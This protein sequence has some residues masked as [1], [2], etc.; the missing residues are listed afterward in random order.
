MSMSLGDIAVKYGCELHGDPSQQVT[1][2][3][4][5]SGAGGEAIAFLANSAYRSQ[6]ATTKARAVILAADDAADCPVATLVTPNP[7][8][9]YAHVALELHP[10][11]ALR[12]G[13][14]PA[15]T[16]DADSN[17]PSSCQIAPGAVVE[18]GVRLGERV[19]VGPNAVVGRG[20][21]I[22][23]DTRLMAGVITYAD[24]TIGH[25]CLLHSGVVV[26]ADGFGI[27]LDASR[28]WV[29]VPQ[30]GS[31]RIGND[32][33]IGANTTVDRG[34]IDDTVIH[35][36]VKLDNH[37]QVAH[38][39]IIGEHTVIAALVGISGSTTIGARC[40]IGG[41]TGFAGHM[42]ICDDVFI[43][44]GTAV[45]SSITKPGYYAGGIATAADDIRK[46]RKNAARFSQLDE[47]ARR[48]RALEKR[49]ER[50]AK[51]SSGE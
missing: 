16:V 11:F 26:G 14:D 1:H 28:A 35:N 51:E 23:D 32:V 31:V 30:L 22:G 34:A 46:W 6:L 2:V 44:A 37:I 18:A 49:V 8:V 20:T 15:A 24:V 9:V 13:I 3:A 38:N 42:E 5:L 27:A 12:A 45:L 33:E 48:L 43:T 19:Y 10:D 4:T 7:Y 21:R 25:R 47:M 29:K 39:C 40:S 17:I 36:G 41:H 50:Q